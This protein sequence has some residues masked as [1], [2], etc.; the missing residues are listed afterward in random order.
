M[1]RRYLLDTGPAFDF[2]FRRRGVDVRVEEVR[3]RGGAKV[4]IGM[5]VLAEVVGGLLASDSRE[6]SWDIARRSL[7][8]LVC[9][10][11]DKTA[12]YE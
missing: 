5:P 3:R 2:L 4:G 12:A 8:K 1:T 11:F 7:G 10:P 6:A 9:W